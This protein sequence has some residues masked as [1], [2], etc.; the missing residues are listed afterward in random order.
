MWS[1][2]INGT[3]DVFFCKKPEEAAETQVCRA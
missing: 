2:I 3:S 1:V